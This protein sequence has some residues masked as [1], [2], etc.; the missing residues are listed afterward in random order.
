MKKFL[1]EECFF[2]NLV[3]PHHLQQLLNTF[4]LKL[5]SKEFQKLWNKFD[6]NNNGCCRISIFLKLI[7][8]KPAE[9]NQNNYNLYHSQSFV[10]DKL[11]LNSNL[12]SSNQPLVPFNTSRSNLMTNEKYNIAD[13]ASLVSKTI[14]ETLDEIK[15]IEE[16]KNQNEDGLQKEKI[17]PKPIIEAQ[18]MV[19]SVP[20]SNTS[21]SEAKMKSMANSFKKMSDFGPNNDLVSFLNNN[22]NEG[23]I[24]LRTAFEFIDQDQIG[25]L[26]AFEFGSV[27]EEFKLFSGAKLMKKFL[28]K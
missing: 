4:E 25:H 7:N 2:K 15:E 10:V 17:E 27:L 1:P 21:L 20:R 11:D 3:L 18:K 8:Y 9:E 16:E 24:L 23:A 6:I 5:S 22:L 26:L 14:C 13:E 12:I 19:Q 28:K